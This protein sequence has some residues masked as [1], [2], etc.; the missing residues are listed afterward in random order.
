MGDYL[1]DMFIEVRDQTPKED[2]QILAQVASH[3]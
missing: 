3:D 2:D 1:K